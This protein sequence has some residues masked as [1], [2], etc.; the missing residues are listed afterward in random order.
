[1]GSRFDKFKATIARI[2]KKKVLQTSS[3]KEDPILPSRLSDDAKNLIEKL[4]GELGP[5]PAAT[6]ESRRAARRIAA[7]F[8]EYSSD[9][10]ITSAKIYTSMLK[11]QI[12]S[13]LM[14]SPI[15]LIF[16]LFNIPIV[17][18]S[19]IAF[20]CVSFVFELKG[21]QNIFKALMPSDE[22]AN[23]HAILEPEDLVEETIVFSS[24]HDTAPEN[25]IQKTFSL[26]YITLYYFPIIGFLM[27]AITALSELLFDI[28]IYSFSPKLSSLPYIIFSFLGCGLTFSS[29]ISIKTLGKDY[30]T[31]AGDN[32]SG[33]AT[34][35]QILRYFSNKKKHGAGLKHTR[36][37]FTS[38]D[39]EE[40]GVQGSDAWFK[41]NDNLLLN[42]KVI[43]FDGLY[44]ADD[45][46]FLTQD[47][48]G[49]VQ[50]SNVLA[51]RCSEIAFSMGYKV[52]TGKLGIMAGETD[53]SSAAKNGY[54]ATTLTSMRPEVKT[55][56]HTLDDKPDKVE[57]EA[58]EEA[59]SIG[60][61]F[62]ET[63]DEALL[64]NKVEEVPKFLDQ[65]R[66][67][68]LTK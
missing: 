49:L 16:T 10:T 44:K 31:G 18:L 43:N 20:W 51:S 60:I 22:A 27:L 24:H 2:T 9:V 65:D 19:L 38:F 67:Y 6:K 39:G 40:C 54:K 48:N 57:K 37:I 52:E 25:K 33:V 21:K 61:R 45:L 46:V 42:A 3:Y 66:K 47:G 68:K 30:V 7:I 4:F 59:I 41:E 12:L 26:K 5:R 58:L 53:A 55:P 1:M 50:L 64:K 13:I 36:L 17:A 56:A 23:V 14:I 11:G 8:E 35:V 29:L 28:F 62:A 32:L 15:I 34:V 63:E